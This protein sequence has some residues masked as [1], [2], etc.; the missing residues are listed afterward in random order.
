M[1]HVSPTSSTQ[2]DEGGYAAKQNLSHGHFQGII[3]N[4]N[5]SN[6]SDKISSTETPTKATQ[7][8]TENPCHR[9]TFS[10][11]LV[12][13]VKTRPRTRTEEKPNLY[14]TANE[15]ASIRCHEQGKDEK[16]AKFS[17]DLDES[18]L[19]Y[20][21]ERRDYHEISIRLP[22]EMEDVSWESSKSIL[23]D[24][25][26]TDNLPLERCLKSDESVLSPI[27]VAVADEEEKG[28]HLLG[29]LPSL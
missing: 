26:G 2:L 19:R 27:L 22:L 3:H 1:H 14:W 21:T 5:K 9:V 11:C 23:Q 28:P 20:R 10:S 25:E 24:R 4:A 15:I 13:A 12:T 8:D 17:N 18:D 7:N 6:E 16:E 29:L